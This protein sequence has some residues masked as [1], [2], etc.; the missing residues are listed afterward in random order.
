MVS[1]RGAAV[2]RVRRGDRS[3]ERLLGWAL[4]DSRPKALC[5]GL[6]SVRLLPGSRRRRWSDRSVWVFL[7]RG[8]FAL[9]TSIFGVGFSWISLDSLVRIESFQWVTLDFRDKNFRSASPG[10]E[11]RR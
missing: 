10:V 2:E 1:A 9:K 7:D 5:S 3:G 8:R 11:R 4:A 6:A